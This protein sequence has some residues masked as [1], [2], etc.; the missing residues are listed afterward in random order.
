[1]I[2]VLHNIFYKL[3]NPKGIVVVELNYDGEEFYL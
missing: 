3:S 2:N 1:M